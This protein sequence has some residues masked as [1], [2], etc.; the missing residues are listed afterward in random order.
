MNTDLLFAG[1]MFL[2]VGFVSWRWPRGLW[3]VYHGIWVKNGEPSDLW[4]G[5]MRASSY[6][7]FGLALVFLTASFSK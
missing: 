2:T 6:V 7:Y 5:W 4:M 1:I 3:L